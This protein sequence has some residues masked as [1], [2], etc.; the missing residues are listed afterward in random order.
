MNTL[1]TLF[2]TPFRSYMTT[3]AG[4]TGFFVPYKM[5]VGPDQD[6]DHTLFG[7]DHRKEIRNMAIVTTIGLPL[8]WLLVATHG[9]ES[10]HRQLCAEAGGRTFDSGWLEPFLEEDDTDD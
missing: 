2:G 8:F 7:C 4:T 1:R 5:W 3:M 10:V 9:F 6:N